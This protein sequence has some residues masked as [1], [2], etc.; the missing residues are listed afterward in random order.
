M[1]RASIFPQLIA[2]QP[3]PFSY[4]ATV[5]ALPHWC[6]L[7]PLVCFDLTAIDG[8]V[9]IKSIPW[10]VDKAAL[11]RIAGLQ[12]PDHVSEHPAPLQPTEFLDAG[13]AGCIFFVNPWDPARIG[14]MLPVML[15]TSHGWE[16]NPRFP[17][18]AFDRRF[19]C[20]LERGYRLLTWPVRSRRHHLEVLADAYDLDPAQLTA[21]QAHPQLDDVV[22][23][24]YPCV[25][26][27]AV[28]DRISRLRI[29][30]GRLI[31]QVS[32]IL[33]DA[34]PIFMG[35]VLTHA[36]EGKASHAELAQ[37]LS[38]FMPEGLEVRIH[39]APVDDHRNLVV[40][41]GH[42]LTVC[43]DILTTSDEADSDA[44]SD[45]D[46]DPGS[47]PDD[48]AMSDQQDPAARQHAPDSP[49][50]SRSRSRTPPRQD[51]PTS[52]RTQA[53]CPC[54]GALPGLLPACSSEGLEGSDSPCSQGGQVG[55]QVPQPP[56][57][58]TVKRDIPGVGPGS[59][60]THQAWALLLSSCR[61]TAL[62]TSLSNSA[63]LRHSE[64]PATFCRQLGR[65]DSPGPFPTSTQLCLSFLMTSPSVWLHQ[66]GSLMRSSSASTPQ[67]SINGC[68]PSM[69][70]VA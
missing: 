16:A 47:G 57:M 53:D 30:P 68:S 32:A 51:T 42:V 13:P 24:G 19:C 28:T 56:A 40:R 18:P 27:V 65:Q 3:Q 29:P 39:G 66:V 8:R 43:Y 36:T 15:Q 20:V 22:L 7:E 17:S 34:R 61:C 58:H 4:F 49:T 69:R 1:T 60:K 67:R 46:S 45:S 26:V 64:Q 50:G 54:D 9:F 52:S 59:V 11:C 63:S 12:D 23:D 48:G 70:L 38:I 14:H 25:G 31:P 35:F 5:L 44:N 41:P 2:I 62:S 21:Q 55:A 33:I 10:R 6:Q 37:E